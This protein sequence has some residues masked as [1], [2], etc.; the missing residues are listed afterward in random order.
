MGNWTTTSTGYVSEWITTSFYKNVSI[1]Y[2]LK[3]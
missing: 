2:T 3:K 1:I